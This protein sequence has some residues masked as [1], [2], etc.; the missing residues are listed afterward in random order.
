MDKEEF[1]DIRTS[2]VRSEPYEGI[3]P[4]IVPHQQVVERRSS[5]HSRS[6]SSEIGLIPMQFM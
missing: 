1:F 5:E 6:P 4:Y 3:R 2:D